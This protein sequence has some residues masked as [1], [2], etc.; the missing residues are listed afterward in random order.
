MGLMGRKESRTA[1][2]QP[3]SRFQGFRAPTWAPKPAWK[4]A[5]K[6]RCTSPRP[7][8]W[9]PTVTAIGNHNNSEFSLKS[10]LPS[11]NSVDVQSI[12]G[13]AQQCGTCLLCDKGKIPAQR[14]VQS[15][16]VKPSSLPQFTNTNTIFNINHLMFWVPWCGSTGST[17]FN[18]STLAADP[19]G[20]TNE[21][22]V[23]TCLGPV[24]SIPHF[25]HW[26]WPLGYDFPNIIKGITWVGIPQHGLQYILGTLC[27]ITF[28]MF[29][30]HS[31]NNL[32]V[33]NISWH[34]IH[35]IN[36]GRT[37]K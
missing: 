14:N 18:L 20:E 17:R 35:I 33:L 32:Q 19:K 34:H 3:N 13:Q 4:K 26:W 5:N 30:A 9:N 22:I 16:T 25:D 23:W 12:G 8:D 29:E 21:V 24:S 6:K 28:D 7:R 36:D 2:L 11:S 1:A 37:I 15:P 31:N 10:F 27:S